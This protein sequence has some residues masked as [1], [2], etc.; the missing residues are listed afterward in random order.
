MIL[1]KKGI[2]LMGR[3]EPAAPLLYGC[4]SYTVRS[5]RVPWTYMGKPD[6][7]LLLPTSQLMYEAWTRTHKDLIALTP[8]FGITS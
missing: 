4:I 1:A 5:H 3:Y 7:F 8:N 6:F 2:L